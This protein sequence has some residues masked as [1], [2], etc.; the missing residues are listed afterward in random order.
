MIYT[1]D[2][3]PKKVC[4]GQM[5][6]FGPKTGAHPHNS[7]STLRFVLKKFCRMKGADRYMKILLVVFREQN[8]FWAVRSFYPLGY[9]LLFDWAWQIEPG[10][11]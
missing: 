2:L 5:G 11:C 8:S 9:F 1:N 7:E 6:C 10:H 4:S 3:Y